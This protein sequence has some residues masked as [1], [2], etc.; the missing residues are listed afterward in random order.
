MINKLKSILVLVLALIFL[1]GI[2]SNTLAQGWEAEYEGV[3]LQGFY[4][5]SFEDT[6][7]TNLTSQVDELSAY[8]DLIWVPNSSSSGYYSMGY[9]PQYWFQHESS[10]GTEDELRQ[11]INAYKKRGTGFI[12]DVVINHRNGVTNWY[13]FPEETDHNGVT[14]KLGLD[15]ICC[16]DEMAYASGQPTPTG[17]ADEGENFD[18]ARDLDHTNSTV[19]GA[20]K[21]YLDFLLN[22]LGY[23]GFRYDMVKGFSPYYVGLYNDAAVPAYSVGEYYDGNYD[24]VTGWIDGTIRN[25]KIQSGAFDF[26]L[27]FAMNS[28]FGYPSDFAKLA[29]WRNDLNANQPAGLIHMDGFR[30]FSVTFIDNHDTY[31]DGGTVFSNDYY[32][33]AAHAFM[34]C[35]PGTPCVFLEHWMEHKADIKHLIDIRKSVG[36]HNQSAVEVWEATTGHYA[37]K[38]YGT[39]GD[40]FIVVGYDEYTP[41]GYSD[42]DIVASGDGYSIWTKTSIKSGADKIVPENDHNGFSVYVKKSS[43]PASWSELYCYVWDNDEERL[44]PVFPG[45]KMTKVVTI[46]GTEYYKY[47]FDSEVTAANVVFSNGNGSQT[48]DLTGITDDTYYSIATINTSGKYTATKLAVSGDESGEPITVYL[49]KASLPADWD[50]VKLYAW[51]KS[52]ATLTYAWPG[53]VIEEL[54]EIAGVTY[55]YYTLPEDV[56]M[57]NLIFNNGTTQTCDIKGV[58]ESAIFRITD[59]ISGKYEVEHTT[60]ANSNGIS[61]YVEKSSVSSWPAVYYYAWDNNNDVIGEPWPG[62][63]ITTTTSIGGVEYYVYTYPLDV[64]EMNVIINN[65]SGGQTADITGVKSDLYLSLNSNFSYDKLDEPITIYFFTGDVWDTVNFYAWDDAQNPLLGEWPGT[66]V[67]NTTYCDLGLKY[68]Y[69]TFAPGIESLNILFNDGTNQTVDIN[70]VTQTTYFQLGKKSGSKY[71]VTSG[72]IPTHVERVERVADCRVYPNPVTDRLCVHSSQEVEAITI[73]DLQGAMLYR[74]YEAIVEVDF[75]PSG[76]YIYQVELENGALQRGKIVKR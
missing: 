45:D 64:S 59:F 13:D 72:K 46:G 23:V 1:Q 22:E 50:E 70:S 20:V 8:F 51:D 56:T 40:L 65:G 24:L 63:K 71:S 30:R 28:A 76:M 16:D 27:K 68:Y 67:E 58:M 32:L 57:A 36:I 19:Q 41:S 39:N 49:E 6:K 55:Y 43:L 10:F 60:V 9:M 21:A 47:S 69:Y 74:G 66:A 2:T 38:V 5:D 25:D 29:W 4:W 14:W 35:S 61:V 48:V 53:N 11:M 34:L 37:A 15:A 3:M 31:R 33:M 73:Y 42:S 7:W 17:A 52:G 26:P 44:S 62:R 54:K 75:L 18:G 12:A